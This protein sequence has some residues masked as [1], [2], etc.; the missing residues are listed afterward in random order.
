MQMAAHSVQEMVDV[1]GPRE[2]LH[3]I[4]AGKSMQLSNLARGGTPR[5]FA[6]L[7]MRAVRPLTIALVK[8]APFNVA[9]IGR[10]ERREQWADAHAFALRNV[11]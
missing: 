1:V 4:S 2:G 11:H 7:V 6:P 9:E 3:R 8:M 5:R 10:A